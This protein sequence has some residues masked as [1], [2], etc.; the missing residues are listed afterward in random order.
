MKPRGLVVAWAVAGAAF[1]VL[2]GS[3]LVHWRAISIE[4]ERAAAERQ[5]LTGEIRLRD[6]QLAAEMR[7]H[8]ALLRE[9]RWTSAGD[10]PST[11][12]TRLADLAREKQMKIVA[13]GPRERQSTP[14]FN[15][16]WHAIQ[17]VAPYPEIRELAARVEGDR[18]ILEDMR[19]ELAPAPPAGWPQGMA[20]LDEVQAR[21][22]MT[23]LEL[24]PPAKRLFDRALAA[25]GTGSGAGAAGSSLAPP[26]AGAGRPLTRD[27]F[28]FAAGKVPDVK[29]NPGTPEPGKPPAP[30][31]G[32]A[33][34][35]PQRPQPGAT[36]PAPSRR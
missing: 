21:F 20:A 13:I 15:K 7:A 34:R 5:R 26:V 30:V 14:Q 32:A 27:P 4:A 25:D 22:R 28:V 2:L 11:F 12:L 3:E 36:P 33:A 23:A 8:S 35:T 10:D 19:L 16:S 29:G 18:G 17:V 31:P 1:L 9:M 6:E 24:S